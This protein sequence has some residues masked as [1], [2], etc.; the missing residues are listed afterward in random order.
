MLTGAE[1]FQSLDD[2][3][4]TIFEGERVTDLPGHPILGAAVHRVA[5]G[6]EW[7]AENADGAI[8]HC[9]SEG[10]WQLMDGDGTAARVI[11]A[12][13]FPSAL[14]EAVIGEGRT[15]DKPTN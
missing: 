12:P 8:L 1:Y 10:K 5:A 6:Y 14:V 3:R 9:A 7:L 13:D 15:L 4:T 11:V 2:G